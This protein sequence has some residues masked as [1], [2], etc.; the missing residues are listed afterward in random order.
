MALSSLL[1]GI[2]PNDIGDY[3]AQAAKTR[4]EQALY[5]YQLQQA[6]LTTQG[7]QQELAGKRRAMAISMLPG[8]LNEPDPAKQA[9]LYGTIK[10]MVEGYDPTLKLPDQWDPSL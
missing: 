6:Q 5:P 8:I 10:P 1:A 3:A 9:A 2:V 4:Q 7:A